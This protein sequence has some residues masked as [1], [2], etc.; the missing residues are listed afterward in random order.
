M[1]RSRAGPA[2]FL[3]GFAG[4]LQT[5]GYA[6]Y[7]GIGAAG[8]VHAGCLAHARRKF[9]EAVK[10]NPDDALAAAVVVAFDAVFAV[11]AGA[12]RAGLDLA[13]RHQRRQQ[14]MPARLAALRALIERTRAAA[15]PASLLGRAAGYALAQW[16]KLTRF[17]DHPE[18]ELSVSVRRRPCSGR[19]AL[20]GK[21]LE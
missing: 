9:F 10:V 15:L 8:M 7:E 1:G 4:W 5:D 14:E 3:R 17:L 13:A 19:G 20:G 21:L 12:R 6:A 18:L 16:P 2:Q 11:D